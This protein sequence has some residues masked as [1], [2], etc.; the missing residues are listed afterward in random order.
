MEEAIGSNLSGYIEIGGLLLAL[1]TFI[2][3]VNKMTRVNRKEMQTISNDVTSRIQQNALKI[4]EIEKDIEEM[5]KRHENDKKELKA[6]L[7]ELRKENN[8]NHNNLSS[9]LD[10]MPTLFLQLLKENR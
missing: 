6:D 8:Q 9:K 10:V 5:K 2:I 4:I 3:I 7:L 1:L